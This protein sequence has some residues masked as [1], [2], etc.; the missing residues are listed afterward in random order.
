MTYEEISKALE[1]SG[2]ESDIFLPNEIFSDL[3]AYMIDSSYVVYA[4]SSCI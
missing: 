1:I 2:K 4:Y 3:Q